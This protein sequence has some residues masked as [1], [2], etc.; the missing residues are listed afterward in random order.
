MGFGSHPRFCTSGV[1][2]LV[3]I[4]VVGKLANWFVVGVVIELSWWVK[5]VGDP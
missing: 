5:L 1:G 2:E 3:G 4:R